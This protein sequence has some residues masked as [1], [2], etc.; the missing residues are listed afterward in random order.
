ME[1]NHGISPETPLGPWQ[2]NFNKLRAPKI[3]NLRA[4]PYERGADSIYY[5]DWMAHRALLLVP[6]QAIVAKYLETFK[7]FPPRAKAASFTVGVA[8]E[9][10]T[11]VSGAGK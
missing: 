2:A 4:D 11:A 10:I 7:E 6:A 8:M 9:K 3:Y 5:G 1:Q